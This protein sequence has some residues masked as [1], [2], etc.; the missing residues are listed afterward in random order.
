MNEQGDMLRVVTSSLRGDGTRAVGVYSPRIH[1]DGKESASLGAAARGES[2][3]GRS[4]VVSDWTI[5][6]YEPLRDES[7]KVIG[8]LFVGFSQR[9]VAGLHKVI[10]NV[11]A[12]KRGRAFVMDTTGNFIVAPPGVSEGG[13][14]L[15]RLDANDRPYVREM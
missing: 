7:G 13:N 12:G 2:Y 9:K 3:R 4:W 6:A 1:P 14:A 10:G 15:E 8:M 5:A 11:K